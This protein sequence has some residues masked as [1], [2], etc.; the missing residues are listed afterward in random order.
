[1]IRTPLR[2]I[3]DLFLYYIIEDLNSSSSIY[4]LVMGKNEHGLYCWLVPNYNTHRH[5]MIIGYRYGQMINNIVTCGVFDYVQHAPTFTT[6]TIAWYLM[7][8]S[9]HGYS[10]GVPATTELSQLYPFW[11]KKII[12]PGNHPA[13][14]KLVQ[15]QLCNEVSM[16]VS[17][18]DLI[19]LPQT[20]WEILKCHVSQC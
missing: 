5:W 9:V 13:F 16:R 7:H 19:S 15:V 4:V 12:F 20:S 17:V 1:M 8:V 18:D 10:M 14:A 6:V 2:K 11:K 3:L